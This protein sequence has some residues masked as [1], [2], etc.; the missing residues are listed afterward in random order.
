MMPQPGERVIAFDLETDNFLEK[1]TTI[2]ALVAY[3]LQENYYASCGTGHGPSS[4]DSGLALLASA[5]VLIAHN[6][7][8]FDIAVLDK[9]HPGWRRGRDIRVIDTLILSQL[10]YPDISKQI[11]ESLLKQKRLPPALMGK[12]SLKAWGYRLG[13]NKDEYTGGFDHWSVEMQS[14]CEQD[15][16]VLVKLYRHLAEKLKAFED[17]RPVELEHEVAR[18]CARMVNTGFY[19]DERKAGELYAT[20]KGEILQV[21]KEMQDIFPPTEVKM[22][23]KTK[24]VPFNPGS[25]QQIEKRLRE[26]YDWKPK[27]FTP[28]GQAEINDDILATLPY[29]E[30]KVLARY[31]MLQKRIGQIAESKN[32]DS[33]PWL[34]AVRGGV[35]YSDINPLGTATRRASHSKPNIGQVP[36]AHNKDVPYG[37]ECREL[38]TVPRGYTLVGADMSSLEMRCLAHYMAHWDQ[39]VYAKAV[40]FG[41]SKDGTDAHSINARALGVERETAKTFIYAFLYGA[42]DAKLGSIVEPHA[43]PNRQRTLGKKLRAD[44][45]LGVPALGKL[46]D[47]VSRKVAASKGLKTVDGGIL[48]VRSDHAALNTLLQ[49]A[50][51][52]VCKLWLLLIEKKCADAGLDPGTD[53]DPWSGDWARCAWVHDE[54]QLAVKEAHAETV[55]RICVE[56]AREAGELLGFRCPLTGEFKIGNNWAETH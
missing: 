2:H 11:D 25:R 29:P 16:V 6:A 49:S 54:V 42:G 26:K 53:E 4:V 24:Y 23:T 41:S 39:G 55:G 31:F 45:L 37:T 46:K 35:L 9:L 38:F 34:K 47:N 7:V 8:R 52:I 33:M 10:I 48:P 32:K 1:A 15:V 28:S 30:A 17:L 51:A 43:K 44:F 3:D 40:A 56:A 27:A 21:E 50:G 20:L 18:W 14:Y 22:K 13:E 19:F 12:H 5:D 36:K